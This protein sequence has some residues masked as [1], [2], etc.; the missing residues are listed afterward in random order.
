[1]CVA[2]NFCKL[3][4]N[5]TSPKIHFPFALLVVDCVYHRFDILTILPIVLVTK[6]LKN[7]RFDHGLL[8]ISLIDHYLIN[9]IIFLSLGKKC[10][11]AKHYC[12]LADNEYLCG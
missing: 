5:R 3:I 2:E 1:M 4:A 10:E 9:H 7:S 6:W 11:E 12:K 8:E